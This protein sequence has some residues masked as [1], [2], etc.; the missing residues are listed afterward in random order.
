M[1][2]VRCKQGGSRMKKET[3]GRKRKKKGLR[4]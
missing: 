2:N 3:R 1:L 4:I